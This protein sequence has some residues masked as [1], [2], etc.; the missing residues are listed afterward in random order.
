MNTTTNNNIKIKPSEM[1]SI[2]GDWEKQCSVLVAKY[3]Q[4]TR[5]DLKFTPGRESKLFKR[6]VFKLNKN[7]NEIIYI[8]KAN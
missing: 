6:L 8:L 7:L 5:E 4:L 3:P 2:T 1:Y